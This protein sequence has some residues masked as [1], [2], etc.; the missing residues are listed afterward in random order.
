M[1]WRK[2]RSHNPVGKVFSRAELEAIGAVCVKNNIIILS[3]EVYD[4]LY[5]APFTRI[6]TLSPE[7]A[8]LTIS[9]GS[10]G[11]AFYATGW[12]VGWVIG[13]GHLTQHVAAV[14]TRVCYSSVS[15]LQEAAAVGFEQAQAHNFW[16]RSK[17][18]MKQKMSRFNAI[19]PELG[20]PFSDPDGGYFVLVNMTDVHL[21]P[22]YP[23]PDHVAAKPRDFH[24]SWFLIHQVGVAAIPPSGELNFFFFPPFLL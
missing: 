9:V 5:Y 20:L 4:R 14:H 18:E 7:I 6:A 16:D 10:V 15:P 2:T 24:L 13:P 12:R 22:D 8:R 17:A 23:L 1:Q 11:K 21:P 19:W 3:D